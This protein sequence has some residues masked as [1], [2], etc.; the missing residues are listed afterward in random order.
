MPDSSLYDMT[1][2]NQVVTLPHKVEFSSYFNWQPG[3]PYDIITGT[4]ANG[5]GTFND[6]PSFTTVPGPGVYSTRFGL[7]STNAV[8]GDVPYN[9]GRLPYLIQ[10][11]A[12][13]SKAFQLNP[14]NKDN[15]RLLTFNIRAANVMNQTR[16]TAVGTVVSSPN[17]GQAITAEDGRRI[18]LGARFSF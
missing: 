11:G 13:L 8:N 5:D 3:I 17:F 10:F 7:L 14:A 16:V 1:N 9:L 15:P 6:R 12:N 18:E 4:D 2:H